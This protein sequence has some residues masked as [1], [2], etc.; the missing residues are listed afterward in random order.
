M[1]LAIETVTD[2]QTNGGIGRR[3][4]NEIPEC[5]MGSVLL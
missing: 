4:W 5:Q 3:I 1:R 2:D